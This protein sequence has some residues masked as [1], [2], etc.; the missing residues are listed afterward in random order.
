[1]KV[2]AA[3]R[4][5]ARRLAPR[6]RVAA[7]RV[8]GGAGAPVIGYAA[9]TVALFLL[10]LYWTFPHEAMLRSMIERA[11]SGTARIG[12]SDVT[13]G[14]PLAYRI[15]EVRIAPPG[16]DLATP[17]LVAR[18]L[19]AAPSVLGLLR[20]S[21]Y[22]LHL[23]AELY[24]GS[25]TADVDLRG[26]DPRLDLTLT[27]IDLSRYAEFQSLM[28]GVPRG[29]VNVKLTVH[30]DGRR[31]SAVDGTLSLRGTSLEL[32][33]GKVRGIAIPDLHFG[34]ARVDGTINNGRLEVTELTGDGQELIVRGTGNILLR[35]PFATSTLGLD[36]TITPTAKA[37]D[38]M[39]LALNLLPGSSG[40]GGARTIRLGGTLGQ[41]RVR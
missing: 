33:S 36:L 6:L 3:V 31:V 19:R 27:D 26:K 9:F 2:A 7:E 28:E 1:M 24:G 13:L 37:P 30:G 14:W 20:G 11:Q 34:E 35:A 21:P 15:G 25:V 10:F 16:T 18:H 17:S 8:K 29:R 32:E 39:R 5:V 22:P 41:P 4:D 38:G 23:Y 40:E 12:V